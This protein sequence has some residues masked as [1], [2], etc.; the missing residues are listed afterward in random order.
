MNEHNDPLDIL[1]SELASVSVSPGF[2]ARVQSRVA[3]RTETETDLDALKEQLAA[4][5]VSPAFAVRVRQQIEDGPSRSR[6]FG[7]F[8]WRW[9]VPMAAAAT[10]AAIALTRGERQET[11]GVESAGVQASAPSPQAPVTTPSSIVPVAPVTQPSQIRAARVTQ[12]TAT[13]AAASGQQAG[14]KLE[15]ITYQPA[16]YRQLWAAAAAAAQVV[17]VAD[18]PVEVREVVI[19]P[20]EVGPVVVQWLVEPAV[21]PGGSVPSIRRVSA[22]A[23]RSDK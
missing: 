10:I 9:A 19:T 5:S 21:S 7:V 15:V 2:A 8:S 16:V 20:V 18:L 6:W 22:A 17:L 1:K 4:V 14:D 3:E 11:T 23:E 12:R 13:A